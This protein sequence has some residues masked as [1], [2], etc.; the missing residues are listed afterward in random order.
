MKRKRYEPPQE[1]LSVRISRKLHHDIK[2]VHKASKKAKVFETQKLVKRL[3]D[4]RRKGDDPKAIEEHEEQLTLL[5][6]VDH[7]TIGNTAF[8]TKILKDNSLR[9]NDF[10]QAALSSEVGENVTTPAKPGTPLAKVQSRLLSS[11]LLAAQIV[12]SIEN[13]RMLLDPTLR[14]P[15]AEGTEED[16]AVPAPKRKK[17]PT[18]SGE[19]SVAHAAMED[20]ESDGDE[21]KGVDDE[22][23]DMADAAIG[24]GVDDGWESGTVGEGDDVAGS[25]GWESSSIGNDD[26]VSEDGDRLELHAKPAVKKSATAALKAKA[27]A[28]GLQSTF[29]PSLSVGFVRGGSEESDWSE[30]GRVADI[31]VKKNRRGQ[32]ARRAIWEKK[33]GRNANHKKKESEESTKFGSVRGEPP[34]PRQLH[35]HPPSS[36]ASRKIKP[37]SQQRQPPDMG[38]GQRRIGPNKIPPSKSETKADQSLHP[39]WEAKRKLK[40]KESAGIIPSQGTKIK[41]S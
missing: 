15:K 38:W 35:N 2:E 32:R 14:G 6:S 28:S 5:K 39:S 7:D 31:D 1:E 40:L 22:N 4:L 37:T 41:F 16:T 30:E 29:L 21:W 17:A 8:K 20:C 19:Q 34:R 18:L 25:D 26:D 12:V 33:Y 3:K 36:G 24:D 13:L 27:S 23:Q 9:E 10:V 11:K